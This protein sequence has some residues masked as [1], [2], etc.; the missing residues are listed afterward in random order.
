MTTPT[1]SDEQQHIV[2]VF[3]ATADNL[4]ISACAGGSKTFTMCAIARTLTP[5]TRTVAL[6]FN[7][8]A[9]TALTE[10]MPYFVQSSTFHKF[11]YDAL[12]ASLGKKPRADG[13]K[14]K[15]ILKE[16]VPDWKVRCKMEGPTLALVSRAKAL[17]FD[18]TAS[19][20]HESLSQIADRFNIEE[21]N[22]EHAATML[23]RSATAPFKTVDFDDMLWLALLLRCPF[24]PVGVLL[25]DEAQDTNVVQRHLLQ[26][27]AA[28]RLIAVGD[29]HQSIYGFRGADAN[30]MN[31]LRDDFN[32]KELTL[33]VSYR[34]SKAVVNEAQ[35]YL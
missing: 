12:G 19:A 35:K 10:K 27:I 11:C 21:A 5:A 31:A 24:P 16:L 18:P 34:C 15:W 3:G 2:D 28:G 25:L 17:G 33:S 6:A 32:M 13:N 9:A 29:P 26:R 23:E 20:Q 7:K 1:L 14:C 8:D 22:L 30:A 4:L